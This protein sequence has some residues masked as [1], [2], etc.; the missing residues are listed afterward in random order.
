MFLLLASMPH[1]QVALLRTLRQ[2]VTLSFADRLRAV[3]PIS[4]NVDYVDSQ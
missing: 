4:V 2:T 1:A 3:G